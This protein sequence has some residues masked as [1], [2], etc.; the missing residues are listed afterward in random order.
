MWRS[1]ANDNRADP[2]CRPGLESRLASASAFVT[3]SVLRCDRS[4]RLSLLSITS[5]RRTRRSKMAD[6]RDVRASPDRKGSDDLLK[7]DVEHR[8]FGSNE[9][10][11]AELGAVDEKRLLRKIDWQ[12]LPVLSLLYLL[13]CVRLAVIV[14]RRRRRNAGA[15]R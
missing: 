14:A 11:E 2:R 8:S 6:L 5:N 1:R 12:L 10:S 4:L 7:A 13:S 15:R 9:V 3:A